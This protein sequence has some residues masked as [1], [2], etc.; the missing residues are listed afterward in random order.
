M[1]LKDDMADDLENVFFNKDEFAEEWTYHPFGGVDYPITPIF[2]NEYQSVGPGG[3][4]EINSTNPNI[5]LRESELHAAP[6]PKDEVTGRGIR[7]SLTTPEPD[8][9]GT[10]LFT[11]RKKR[12]GQ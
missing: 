6:G 1:T 8:G 2:D 3:S 12:G 10:I 5:R 4:V 7:Y 11:L 9:V